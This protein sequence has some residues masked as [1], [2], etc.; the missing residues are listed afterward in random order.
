MSTFSFSQKQKSIF[1]VIVVAIALVL[2]AWF[3]LRYDVSDPLLENEKYEFAEYVA[4]NFDGN[5]LREF[6]ISLDY[7][8]LVYVENSPESF[9]NCK[10]G[11][12]KEL[13]N[14]DKSNGVLNRITIIGNSVEE[15]I[16]KGETYDLKYIIA[17]KEKNDFHGFI[18]DIYHQEEKYPYL[19]KIFDSG[20]QGFEKLKI[21]VFEID[22]KKFHILF[23]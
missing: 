20:N 6:G 18:D 14:Y 13:C 11:F 5:S 16:T 3:T 22:Y 1:L 17:N 12:S 8:N 21:K 15:I 23:D 4:Q 2:S 10:V 7:L 9:K 19:K